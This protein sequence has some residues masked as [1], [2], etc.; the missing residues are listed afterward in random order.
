MIRLGLGA[1]VLANS[2]ATLDGIGVMV[3]RLQH[4]LGD[5]Q[6]LSVQPWVFPASALRGGRSAL[7]ADASRPYAYFPRSFKISLLQSLLL[8]RSMPGAAQV[9]AQVDLFHSLDY[10]IPRLPQTPVVA[11]LHD[12]IPIMAP[13]WVNP[14]LRR[15]KN[16]LFLRTVPWADHVLALSAAMVPD[17][18]RYLGVNEHKISVVHPGVDQQYFTAPAPEQLHQVLQH[19]RLRPGY[20]LSVGT[21]QPRKNFARLIRAHRALP[22][23]LR[24]EHPLV[25]VGQA[26]WQHQDILREI[27]QMQAEGDGLWL[28]FVPQQDLYALYRA[29]QVFA[30]PS[31]Y[32]GFGLP[33]L[34]AFASAVPVVTSTV[35][36]LPEAAGDA[37]L[38]VNPESEGELTEAL[39]TV[40]GD[41]GYAEQLR[42]RGL[43]RARQ[44]SWERCAAATVAVYRRVVAQA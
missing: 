16:A 28:Q 32:E 44:L 42:Q 35:S 25:I 30:F 33:V 34:E 6:S 27:K 13:H 12:A 31:L 9:S 20:V 19:Y 39:R 40:L 4:H 26:G 5:Q 14:R 10:L 36:A 23:A 41:S 24:R 15:I 18:V 17:L 1:T 22:L 21:L 37:A 11:T 38:L 2:G 8:K 7:R 43:D 3:D 29:A